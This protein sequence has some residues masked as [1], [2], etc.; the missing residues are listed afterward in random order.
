MNLS[1][2]ASAI[3]L[4]ASAWPAFART[5]PAIE[6]FPEM[7]DEDRDSVIVAQTLVGALDISFGAFVLT[8]HDP[9][10]WRDNQLRQ[11]RSEV[12]DRVRRLQYQ[13][14]TEDGSA[15][16]RTIEASLATKVEQAR[17]LKAESEMA[18]LQTAMT[19]EEQPEIMREIKAIKD[20]PMSYI[21]RVRKQ[22]LPENSNFRPIVEDDARLFAQQFARDFLYARQNGHFTAEAYDHLR[23][24]ESVKGLS[25]A[26]KTSRLSKA[27][28][29]LLAARAALDET[30]L[31]LSTGSFKVTREM[32]A[33]YS[34]I[35][36]EADLRVEYDRLMKL[37]VRKLSPEATQSLMLSIER[38]EDFAKILNAEFQK[39]LSIGGIIK[40]NVFWVAKRV[41]VL[42]VVADMAARV[43]LFKVGRDPGLFP[44]RT[45]VEDQIRRSG[46][47][48]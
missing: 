42:A 37:N 44:F 15:G 7:A 32:I 13:L 34:V 20:D 36:H 16:L 23:Q 39:S 18:F 31:D 10:S 8:R 11:H 41:S 22:T 24:L 33:P 43:A 4:A 26:E 17:L 3:F 29:E 46:Q 25:A 12:A 2:R 6:M 47:Q 28:N 1:L 21:I 38:E 30:L 9:R 35:G 40:A 5:S 27:E 48:P 45:Y 19:L 14:V